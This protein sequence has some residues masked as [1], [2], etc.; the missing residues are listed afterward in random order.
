MNTIPFIETVYDPGGVLMAGVKV[1]DSEH[2]AHEITV[3]VSSCIAPWHD[4]TN[5]REW[6]LRY[7]GV[8]QFYFTEPTVDELAKFAQF[9][10]QV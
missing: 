6:M 1:I 4:E 2:I 7:D 3:E 10:Y 9:A 8:V 5:S